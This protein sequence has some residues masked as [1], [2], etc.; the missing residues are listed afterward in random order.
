M[1]VTVLLAAEADELQHLG[2]H[3]TGDR[4]RLSDHLERERDV[5]VRRAVGQQAE[6][7]EDAADR[8]PEVGIFQERIDVTSR[9]LTTTRPW[10]G[11]TSCSSSLMIV[12]LPEPEGPMKKTNSPFSIPTDTSSR[13]GRDAFGYVFVT[14]SS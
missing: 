8:A 2:H 13:D 5:L 3:P 14:C 9:P 10:L 1:R 6:V 7:L 12:D 4:L 11:V